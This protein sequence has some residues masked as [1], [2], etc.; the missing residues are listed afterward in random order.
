M[1]GLAALPPEQ[2][3]AIVLQLWHRHTF[4]E[5][6]EPLDLSPNTAAG[7]YRYGLQKLR[8]CLREPETELEHELVGPHGETALGLDAPPALPGA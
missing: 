8:A 6:A 3:E 2:R 7:R 1:E 4:G 5:I